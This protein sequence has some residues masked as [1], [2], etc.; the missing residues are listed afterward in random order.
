MFLFKGH[1]GS[2]LSLLKPEEFKT[3]FPTF[4]SFAVLSWVWGILQPGASGGMNS[5]L[6]TS[7]SREP[8]NALLMILKRQQRKGGAR[9]HEW[10][11]H[12]LQDPGHRAPGLGSFPSASPKLTTADRWSAAPS[13]SPRGGGKGPLGRARQ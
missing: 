7:F 4:V 6:P 13:T 12:P 1:L 5:F 11:R 8:E 2:F 10:A 9:D 3:A